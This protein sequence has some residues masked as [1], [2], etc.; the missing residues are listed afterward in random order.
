MRKSPVVPNVPCVP[1]GVFNVV[2]SVPR[3][4][5]GV[6]NGVPRVPD[7]WPAFVMLRIRT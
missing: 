7:V 6:H 4:P 1:N 2:P 5:N 3:V